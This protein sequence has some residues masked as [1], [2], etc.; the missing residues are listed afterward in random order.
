MPVGMLVTIPD[1]GADFYDAVMQH[2]DWDNREKPAGYIS[3]HA[4]PS[5]WGWTVFDVWESQ[6]DFERFAEERLGPA[7]AAAAGG[8]PPKVEPT[9][10]PLHRFEQG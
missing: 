6:A 5:P 7:L 2:L 3:H 8:E 4:G 10:I 1:T 9:F